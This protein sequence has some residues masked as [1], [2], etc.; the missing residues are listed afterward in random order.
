MSALHVSLE[1]K[2]RPECNGGSLILNPPGFLHTALDMEV[3]VIFQFSIEKPNEIFPSR[4]VRNDNDNDN[5]THKEVHPTIVGGL[6]L[7]A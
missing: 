5:D 1:V 2:D 4:S 6:A 3:I 7:Q